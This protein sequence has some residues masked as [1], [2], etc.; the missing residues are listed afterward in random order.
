VRAMQACALTLEEG[1]AHEAEDAAQQA[2]ARPEAH[3]LVERM[4]E[5]GT[6][7]Q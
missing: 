4:C 2:A 3:A 7:N 5:P 6:W 1:L